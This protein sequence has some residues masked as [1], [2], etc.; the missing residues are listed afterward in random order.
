MTDIR[1]QRGDIYYA[2]LPIMEGSVQRG[3]RPVLVIQ[4]NIGN[5]YSKTIHI[6]PI[7]TRHMEKVYPMHVYLNAGECGMPL[8]SIVLVEQVMVIDK[9]CLEEYVTSIDNEKMDEVDDAIVIQLGLSIERIFDRYTKSKNKRKQYKT[10][11]IC[12]QGT[13]TLLQAG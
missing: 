11:N 8:D 13:D 10:T 12:R 4:N 2:Q 1:I 7:T 9:S 5:K 6:A 3:S